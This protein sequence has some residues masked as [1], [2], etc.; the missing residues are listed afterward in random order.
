ML[1]KDGLIDEMQKSVSE[2]KWETEEDLPRKQYMDPVLKKSVKRKTG[3]RVVHPKVRV[4]F[5]IEIRLNEL[6]DDACQ[7]EGF[8]KSSFIRNAI[9]RELRRLKYQLE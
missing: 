2:F 3:P 8:Q 5:N 7:N 1:D 4:T 6:L 9:E